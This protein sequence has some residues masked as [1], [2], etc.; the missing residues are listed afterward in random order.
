MRRICSKQEFLDV[1][2]AELKTWL[3]ERGYDKQLVKSQV[4]RVM[5]LSQQD[6][7][8]GGSNRPNRDGGW[9]NRDFVVL[10]YHPAL[11]VSIYN[12]LESL[13]ILL[14][15]DEE[16]SQVFRDIPRVSFRRAKTLRD[17]LVRSKLP[18]GEVSG[19]CE[20]CTDKRCQMHESMDMTDNFFNMDR[21][22]NFKLRKGKLYCNSKFVIYKLECRTCHKQYIGSTIRK[23]R[24]RFNIYNLNTET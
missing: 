21:T 17:T 11:T 15:C 18:S 23:F 10:T 13:Q 9:D 19:S 4:D 12:I 7:L 22:R 20:G 5:S 3:G 24:D 6:A 8:S 2:L 1:R 14:Q 16:H